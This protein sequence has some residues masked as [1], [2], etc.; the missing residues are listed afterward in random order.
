MSRKYYTLDCDHC[1]DEYT[2]MVENDEEPAYCP[3]CGVE[4]YTTL[5]DEDD[6]DD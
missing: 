1:G 5:A 6:D 4:A 3:I 2:V